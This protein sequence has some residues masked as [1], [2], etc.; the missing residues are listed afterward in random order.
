[1]NACR[2]SP[3]MNA[4]WHSPPVIRGTTKSARNVNYLNRNG[5]ILIP[6]LKYIVSLMVEILQ[7]QSSCRD[8][9]VA[10]TEDSFQ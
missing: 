1:M 6:F 5:I 9:E 4:L 7:V 3:G 2:R 8:R 10:P